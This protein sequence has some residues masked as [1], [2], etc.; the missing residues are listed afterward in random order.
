MVGRILGCL[1]QSESILKRSIGLLVKSGLLKPKPDI[2]FAY[3]CA[4]FNAK[5]ALAF[6][7]SA[8]CESLTLTR[9][10]RSGLEIFGATIARFLSC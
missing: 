3:S 10:L 5:V 6:Y 9:F 8:E 1:G 7:L 2:A 4:Q